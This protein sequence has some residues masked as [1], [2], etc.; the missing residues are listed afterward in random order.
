MLRSLYLRD[1]VLVTELQLDLGAGFTVLTGETGAG[2]SILL[3][4]LQLALGERGDAHS[5]RSGCTRCEIAL[6]C[7]PSPAARGW[8]REQGFDADDD[9]RLILR[10]HIERAALKPEHKIAAPNAALNAASS[11]ALGET[12][13]EAKSRAWINGAPA[14]LTQLRALAE[15]VMDIHGQH[16]WQ[17]LTKAQHARELLDMQANIATDTLRA[18]WQTWQNA[19]Q[20]RIAAQTQ[21][22]ERA[23]TLERLSWQVAQVQKLCPA[24][25]EWEQLSAEHQRLSHAQSLLEAAHGALQ[26]LAEDDMRGHSSHDR[27][28]AQPALQ[29][30]RHAAAALSAHTHIEPQFH[31]LL[32][33]LAEAQTLIDDVCRA[34][35]SYAQ[36][37]EPDD[38][39]LAELDSRM[40][41]WLGLARRLR[42]NPQDLAHSWQAWQAEIE[43]LTQANDP[44][45]LEAAEQQAHRA[46]LAEAQSVHALRRAAAAPLAEHVSSAMQQLGMPGSRFHIALEPLREPQALG[47]EQVEFMFAGHAGVPPRPLSKVASGG[48]LSRTAL[49]LAVCTSAQ[50]SVPTLIFDEVDAGIGGTTAI[51]VGKLLQQ[52]GQQRQVLAITHLAQVAACATEHFFIQKETLG[53]STASTLRRLPPSA[54]IA[55]LARMLGG[56][57]ST[58]LAHAQEL[59][60]N[61]HTQ[62]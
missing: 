37:M 23:A 12:K 13:A 16:A 3:G 43:A 6:E 20:A 34:L 19:K 14:T 58:G 56:Q 46:W 2:K 26:H 11:A 42:L 40:A 48:E 35:H 28:A 53:D 50:S 57:S 59:L 61:A 9:D 31:A 4:A 45:T 25:A 55:E 22:Q 1:F 44:Q 17:S 29:Q 5:I 47:L 32:Q 36:K 33:S 60:T 52:L 51:T 24:P 10:R 38:S 7:E 18:L 41:L 27:T 54:R 30:L 15:H 39:A 8:L 49:A 21:A 62:P